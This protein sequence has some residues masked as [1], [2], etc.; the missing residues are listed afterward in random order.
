[1]Q[2]GEKPGDESKEEKLVGNATAGAP[3]ESTT[4]EAGGAEQIQQ[5]RKKTA[6]EAATT[7]LPLTPEVKPPPDVEAPPKPQLDSSEHEAAGPKPASEPTAVELDP[8][9]DADAKPYPPSTI[10]PASAGAD[11][12]SVDTEGKEGVPVEPVSSL[13]DETA[14]TDDVITPLAS[15][16][17]TSG[18]AAGAT[19]SAGSPAS[20]PA[21]PGSPAS[22]TGGA[23]KKKK[24]RRKSSVSSEQM[25]AALARAKALAASSSSPPAPASPEVSKDGSVA[26]NGEDGKA[27]ADATTATVHGGGNA[28]NEDA[29]KEGE[30]GPM[31]GG[32]I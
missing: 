1:M 29:E 17:K 21:S 13:A 3:A 16:G 28:T 25:K 8:A 27:A 2:P 23:K 11:A 26:G 12:I 32:L 10:A 15:P 9:L 31:L 5:G 24:K 20:S 6:E 4:L 19:V 7:A 30:P 18:A 14:E 22:P